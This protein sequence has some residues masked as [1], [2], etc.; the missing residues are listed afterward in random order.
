MLVGRFASDGLT[1][2]L[3]STGLVR[4]GGL[5]ITVAMVTGL[6]INTTPAM[7]AAFM[8]IGLGVAALVPTAF[9]AGAQIPGVVPGAAIATLATVSYGAFFAGPPGIGQLSNQVTLRGAL[10]V[11]AA[12]GLVI[13]VLAPIVE[14][15]PIG[16]A[17]WLTSKV[18]RSSRSGS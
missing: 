11:V 5:L 7:I 16:I 10:L 9:R 8:C 6:A 14:G 12:A 3:G 17:R 13:A 2:R 15:K 1:I 18:S 4:Y